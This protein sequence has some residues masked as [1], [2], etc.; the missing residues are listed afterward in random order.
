M[1]VCGV[2]CKLLQHLCNKDMD[3]LLQF[4][5]CGILLQVES[6]LSTYGNENGMIQVSYAQFYTVIVI[7]TLTETT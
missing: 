2:N 6:L 7:S 4:E 1:C 5:K 3:A